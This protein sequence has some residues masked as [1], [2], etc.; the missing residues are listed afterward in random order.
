MVIQ[1]FFGSRIGEGYFAGAVLL[2]AAPCT[3]MVFVWSELTKG[4]TAYT[5][6]QVSINDIIVLFLYAQIVA[7]LLGVG[8]VSV[9]MG[10][11]FLSI[12]IFIVIA[13][14]VGIIVRKYVVMQNGD[15]YFE[16][17]F[18]NKYD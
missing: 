10:T 14:A 11:L 4:G 5:L 8:N 9:P 1:T 15:D 17:D 3:A 13:L 7:L 2:G 6:L 12:L 16:T 18:V